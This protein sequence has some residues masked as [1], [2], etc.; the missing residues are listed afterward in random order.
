VEEFLRDCEWTYYEGGSRPRI[1]NPLQATLGLTSGYVIDYEP[2]DGTRYECSLVVP[3]SRKSIRYLL[4][5][6]LNSIFNLGKTWNVSTYCANRTAPLGGWYALRPI[7]ASLNC[8]AGPNE[9]NPYDKINEAN[10]RR[11]IDTIPLDYNDAKLGR[12][13]RRAIESER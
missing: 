9:L 5:E 6:N 8:G 12:L 11:S 4:I 3:L 13:V 7:F 2:G 10:V 1:S